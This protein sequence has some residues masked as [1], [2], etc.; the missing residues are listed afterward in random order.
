MTN[1]NWAEFRDTGPVY[2][3]AQS[4]TGECPFTGTVECDCGPAP[5]GEAE[6]P[7]ADW[8][9]PLTVTPAAEA[10]LDAEAGS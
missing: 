7:T 8:P 5:E 9:V 1:D 3:Y 6:D 2:D 10:L 4:E